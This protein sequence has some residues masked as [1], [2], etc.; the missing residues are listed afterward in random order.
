MKNHVGALVMAGSIAAGPVMAAQQQWAAGYLGWTFDGQAASAWNIDQQIWIAQP[1]EASYWTINW[2][3]TGEQGT[4]GYMGLQ[5]GG[6]AQQ[7]R[8]SL[9]NATD[10]KGSGCQTFGGEGVGYTCTVPV[11]I[12]PA[13]F[14]RLRLWRTDASEGGQWWGG[15]LIEADTSGKLKEHTIGYIKVDA[16]HKEIDLNSIHNFSEYFG[17]AVA[18][19]DEVPLSIVGFTPPA[20]N[21]HGA[22]TGVYGSYSQ[23]KSG[24]KPAGNI[25]QT[26]SENAGAIYKMEPYDF[27]FAKGGL[28]YLGGKA[29]QQK[30]DPKTHPTPPDMPDS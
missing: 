25:C 20:A 22:G 13:K 24:T 11:T 6:G 9:W 1:A 3:W 2:S 19:C 26:G 30:L 21:Y 27:G 16:K 15:W 10:A 18:R 12:D 17:G 5:Q 7:V 29:D 14:Y 4:S 8:F 23:T 28:I